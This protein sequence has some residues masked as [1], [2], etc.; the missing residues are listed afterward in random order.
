MEF[1]FIAFHKNI[2]ED[3]A[4]AQNLV[5]ALEESSFYTH[6]HEDADEL[7]EMRLVAILTQIKIKLRLCY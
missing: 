7:D 4:H 3:I 2:E 5:S 1:N 6:R